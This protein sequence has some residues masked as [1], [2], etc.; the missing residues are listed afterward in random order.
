MDPVNWKP[1]IIVDCFFVKL[2]FFE[3]ATKFEKISHLFWHLHK[4][5]GR[6]FSNFVAFSEYPNFK[7]TQ[8]ISFPSFL[9]QKVV[10]CFKRHGTFIHYTYRIDFYHRALDIWGYHF[11]L[12]LDKHWL[13]KLVMRKSTKCISFSYFSLQ[14]VVCMYQ[15]SKDT[16]NSLTVH[17]PL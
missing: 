8:F 2:Q 4:T 15:V 10:S 6:L 3:K 5:S 11:F 14:K 17:V 12:S 9:L 16:K 13:Q 7:S 1:L